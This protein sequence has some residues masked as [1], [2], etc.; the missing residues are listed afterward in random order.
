[1]STEL[2]PASTNNAYRASN[3]ITESI[4]NEYTGMW[5]L[6]E[7]RE[8]C[9]EKQKTTLAGLEPLTSIYKSR[10]QTTAHFRQ[11]MPNNGFSNLFQT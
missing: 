8:I 9:E 4:Y 3:R 1:M 6:W 5:A 10:I 2:S 7:L 11:L